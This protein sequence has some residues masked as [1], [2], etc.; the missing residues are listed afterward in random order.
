MIQVGHMPIALHRFMPSVCQ[1]VHTPH[2]L[3]TRLP[4]VFQVVAALDREY[5]SH[6]SQCGE[7]DEREFL[8]MDF[9]KFASPRWAFE[10][11]AAYHLGL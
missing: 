5:E 11:G 4:I 3:N 6:Y 10:V 7:I 2:F 1:V 8:T 9:S